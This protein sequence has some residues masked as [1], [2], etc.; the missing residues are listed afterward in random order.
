MCWMTPGSA[1]SAAGQTTQPIARS[2]P[3]RS[4]MIPPGSTDWMRLL[5]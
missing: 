4:Q 2:G 5:S 3:I 1:I